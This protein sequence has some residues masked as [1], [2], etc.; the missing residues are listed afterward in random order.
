MRV[1]VISE[2]KLF[3]LLRSP[4]KSWKSD[5]NQTRVKYA[6]GFLRYVYEVQSHVELF[7]ASY[8]DIGVQV[9]LS[10]IT[11]GLDLH[12]LHVNFLLCERAGGLVELCF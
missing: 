2:F 5:G 4:L 9:S 8:K 12:M 1:T 11:I 6:I 7:N 10:P 3:S